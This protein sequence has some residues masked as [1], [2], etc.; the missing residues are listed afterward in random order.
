M[1]LDELSLKVLSCVHG[2]SS[3][4]D[5]GVFLRGLPSPFL[6]GLLCSFPVLC[7]FLMNLWVQVD[8]R[9]LR[10]GDALPPRLV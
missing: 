3:R 1:F 9:S 2:I 7:D 8:G 6:P 4:K 5:W 10:A